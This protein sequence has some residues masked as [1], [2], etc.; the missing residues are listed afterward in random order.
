M[1]YNFF[2]TH[3]VHAELELE[4]EREFAKAAEEMTLG[5]EYK[6]EAELLHE[7]AARDV[8]ESEIEISKA[9]EDIAASDALIAQAEEDRAAATLD[10][11]RSISLFEEAST[12]EEIATEAEERAAEYEAIV[13]TREGQSLKDGESL[14]KTETGAIEDAE[15]VAACTAIPFLNLLCEAFGAITETGFQVTAAFEGAKSALESLSAA[16]ARRKEHAELLIA[17]EKQEEAAR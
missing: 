14:V 7:Q 8:A 3:D 10:E 2:F 15:G 11:E 13:K 5:E 16:S 1:S 4:A 9:R 6:E 12:S 17:L